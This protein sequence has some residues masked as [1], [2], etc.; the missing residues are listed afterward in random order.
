[1][2]YYEGHN[3]IDVTAFMQIKYLIQ[4][5]IIINQYHLQEPNVAPRAAL[6]FKFT[7]I[8]HLVHMK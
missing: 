5:V 7:L 4:Q 2:T 1:M 6:A 8:S 3:R